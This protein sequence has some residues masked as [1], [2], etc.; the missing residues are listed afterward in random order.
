MH[1]S[2]AGISQ[3]II[4]AFSAFLVFKS[5]I[6]HTLQ[7]LSCI[8]EEIRKVFFVVFL[9]SH[10]NSLFSTGDWERTGATTEPRLRPIIPVSIVTT[11]RHQMGFGW[12]KELHMLGSYLFEHSTL[13]VNEDKN[14]IDVYCLL[15]LRM[16]SSVYEWSIFMFFFEMSWAAEAGG[17]GGL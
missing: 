1:I 6:V 10:P 5:N 13:F 3:Y 2:W 4:R 9:I 17:A 15:Y 16:F 12:D 8:L 14:M 11:K 7:S